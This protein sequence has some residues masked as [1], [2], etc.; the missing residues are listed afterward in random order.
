MHIGHPNAQNK[1][2]MKNCGNEVVL[3]STSKEKDLGVWIDDKLKFT[4][5]AR[6]GMAKSNQILGLTK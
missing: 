6:H 5:H 1:Y 4:S 3:E 2:S